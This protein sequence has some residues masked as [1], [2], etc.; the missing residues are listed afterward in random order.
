M[1][2]DDF[3]NLVPLS[4]VVRA[5]NDATIKKYLAGKLTDFR[6]ENATLQ[7]TLEEARN[8]LLLRASTAEAHANELSKALEAKSNELARITT[9]LR[10]EI[11]SATS[12]EREKSFNAQQEIVSKAEEERRAVAIKHE[13]TV[14]QLTETVRRLEQDNKDLLDAK[15]RL[16]ADVKDLTAQL[17][18]TR[19]EVAQ[20]KQEGISIRAENKS[21]S[22]MIH[23][24]EKEINQQKVK[25]AALD[26][27]IL[28][29][30][31]LLKKMTALLDATNMQKASLEETATHIK[32]TS[33]DME[34]R[35]AVLRGE[36]KKGNQIIATLQ[37]AL[38]A[39][40]LKVAQ[41]D[42]SL[43]RLQ[44]EITAKERQML[45]MRSNET[46]AISLKEASQRELEQVKESE[47]TLS[48]R[49][50]ECRQVISKNNDVI[51]FLQRELLKMKEGTL[52]SPLANHD[53]PITSSAP[54]SSYK[55]RAKYTPPNSLPHHSSV[56]SQS[57]SMLSAP[58]I[59]TPKDVAFSTSQPS[60]VYGTP[61]TIAPTNPPSTSLSAPSPHL[62]PFSVAYNPP[63]RKGVIK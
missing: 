12:Q 27:Q 30:D 43:H 46:H 41:K 40:K 21:V 35:I 56:S 2:I 22:H 5:G 23:E 19:V 42:E 16:D 48:R 36:I 26:Q 1:K 7:S 51:E 63:V 32:S 34:E 62:T 3:K 18:T 28:D 20:Y 53:I 57:P 11:S 6:V 9:Q 37:T 13:A 24:H 15:Y 25:I 59:T 8:T 14:A 17:H 29:K 10:A 38:K 52:S 50:E 44:E 61:S 4:L 33:R 45:V 31:E 47:A 58:V 54:A 55:F 49:L 60:F 39:S